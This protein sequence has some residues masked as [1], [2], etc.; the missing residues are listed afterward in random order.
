[1]TRNTHWAAAAFL[2]LVLTASLVLP[3]LT[4]TASSLK[5]KPDR[6]RLHILTDYE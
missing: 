2:A 5:T 1:M 6:G 3:P 4:T